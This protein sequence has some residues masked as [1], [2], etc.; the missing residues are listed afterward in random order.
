[1]DESYVG[2]GGWTRTNTGLINS[3]NFDVHDVHNVL[4]VQQNAFSGRK[5]LRAFCLVHW[6]PGWTATS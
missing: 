1:M 5:V 4:N 3:G 6:T 2:W